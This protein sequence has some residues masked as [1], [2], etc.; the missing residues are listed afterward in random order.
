[1]KL[2]AYLALAVGILSFSIA[3]IFIRWSGAPTM[4][5]LFY[6]SLFTVILLTPIG[7]RRWTRDGWSKNRAM[8]FV[9][10]A[11]L[12]T[13]LDQIFWGQSLDR[14]SVA[15]AALL[16]HI[17]PLWVAFFAMVVFHEKLKPLFW[18]GLAAVLT[19][20]VTVIGGNIS[21][22]P[23]HAQGDLL[24]VISSFFY[25]WYFLAMQKGREGQDSFTS[26]WVSTMVSII[27][28]LI[29]IRALGISLLGYPGKSYLIFFVLALMANLGG[30]YLVIYALGNLPA[31]VV[32]PTMVLLP[33]L[34]ALLAVPLAGEALTAQQALGGL[35]TVG[36]VYLINIS[37][38][39]KA[40]EAAPIHP[41]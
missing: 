16:N 30:V 12:F 2:R 25:G 7:I 8:S 34:T 5:A 21:I 15:N 4:V 10:L 37:H 6:S 26:L 28:L 32:T 29:G 22:S 20:V 41:V 35:V 19:G 17:S 11:G 1:M 31:S 3:P 36:G 14:T 40:R 13:S 9:I 38:R 27:G 18:I 33:V 24:A 23:E 39:E